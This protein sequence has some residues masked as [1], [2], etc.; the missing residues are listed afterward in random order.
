MY[1]TPAVQI[2]RV[3][4]EKISKIDKRAALLFGTIEYL[5][6]ESFTVQYV[7]SNL[8]LRVEMTLHTLYS[9][10][11]GLLPQPTVFAQCV[12]WNKTPKIVPKYLKAAYRIILEGKPW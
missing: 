5:D 6:Y 2:R 9:H 4:R 3:G 10:R 1:S 7:I 8:I 12:L 11:N